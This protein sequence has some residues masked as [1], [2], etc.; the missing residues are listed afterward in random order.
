MSPKITE[1]VYKMPR[2]KRV[3]DVFVASSVLLFASP[4]YYLL[5]SQ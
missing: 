5:Y 3:F 2:S 1:E 4:S